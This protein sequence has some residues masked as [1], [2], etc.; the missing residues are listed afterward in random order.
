MILRLLHW[1]QSL[2]LAALHLCCD[3]M[4]GLPHYWCSTTHIMVTTNPRTLREVRGR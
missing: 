1:L 4:W 3:L 2:F